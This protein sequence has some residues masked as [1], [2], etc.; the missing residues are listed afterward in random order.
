MSVLFIIILFAF[1]VFSFVCLWTF[2]NIFRMLC[3][4]GG[5]GSFLRGGDRK[6]LMPLHKLVIP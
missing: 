3:H 4:G 5:G 1:L 6:E 2:Y